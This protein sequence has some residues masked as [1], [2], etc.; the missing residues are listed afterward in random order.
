MG[1]QTCKYQGRFNH[2]LRYHP[3]LICVRP[4]LGQILRRWTCAYW[5]S[6]IVAMMQPCAPPERNALSEFYSG[7]KGQ[8]WTE[9]WNWMDQCISHCKWYEVTCEM[10]KTTKLS[11]RSNGLSGTLSDSIAK[12][13]SL[14]FLDLSDND[15]KVK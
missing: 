1:I 9:S 15:I 12:L 5:T 2:T 10:D 7:A 11:L 3:S 13:T 8:E 4:T 6:S 14:L